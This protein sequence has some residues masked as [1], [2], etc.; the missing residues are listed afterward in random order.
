MSLAEWGGLSPSRPPPLKATISE[1]KDEFDADLNLRL[2]I[3]GVPENFPSND[4]FFWVLTF[5][6]T[7]DNS[8]PRGYRDL[9][10]ENARE[11]VTIADNRGQ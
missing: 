4:F 9:L 8:L 2:K 1:L 3:L 5:F 6:S 10:L 11:T 7:L